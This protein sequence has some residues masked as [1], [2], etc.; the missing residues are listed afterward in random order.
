M[1]R[2]DHSASHF[3]PIGAFAAIGDTRTAAIVDDRGEIGW[4]CAPNFDAPSL[5][6][7]IL[8]PDRGGRFAVRPAHPFRTTRRYFP[9][10][11][12]LESTFRTQS[13]SLRVT[14]CMPVRNGEDG[15][16]ALAP[17]HEVLRKIECVEGEIEVELLCEPRPDYGRRAPR[18]VKRGVCGVCL[19]SGALLPT[20]RSDLPLALDPKKRRVV[21]R[22]TLRAGDTRWA[23]LSIDTE[24]PEALAP[25]GEHAERR[26]SATSSAWRGW[27]ERCTYDGFSPEHVMRSALALK[28]MIFSPS[29]AVVAA[30]TTSLPEKIGGVRNWDYRYCWLRDA[31]LVMNALQSLCFGAEADA[32]LGWLLHATR[33]TA[34]RFRPLY[35][36]WGQTRLPE[37][38]LE[39]LRG[40]RD[41]RPVRVGNAATEQAQ[42]DIYGA[43]IGAA[44]TA[45]L[46]GAYL[47]RDE[48]R[49]L[50]RMGELLCDLWAQADEGLWEPRGVRRHHTHS[51]FM[52]LV[53]FECLLEM[54]EAEG[55]AAPVERFSSCRDAIRDWME[56]CAWNDRLGAYA[57]HEDA[58]T[59]D[60]A[61]LQM[62]NLGGLEIL[63]RERL[64]STLNRILEDLGDGPL[65]K[66]YTRLE[67][68][69][70]GEEGAFVICSFW[71]VE[72]LARLG[73]IDEAIERFDALCAHTND[74]GLLA[75]EIDPATGE[76]LGNTP[77]AFSHVGLINAAIAIDR[78]RRDRYESVREA[79]WSASA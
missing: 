67:D 70:P 34:P 66:R 15:D 73:R 64:E 20:L 74:V 57:S 46:S 36:V 16:D 19:A 60:A 29:G 2:S 3:R 65:I 25:L 39:H 53:G 31:T 41:S 68:G 56:E 49:L 42:I 76:A 14:D 75:E 52:C 35:S 50:V 40:H 27:S 38:S 13:G 7:S 1:P 12:V 17:R 48:R 54:H 33:L 32:F 26:L 58:E 77:Q 69:L 78:A 45:V 79:E 71:G 47:Q 55:L 18:P 4:L 11:N 63:P 5:F 9:R 30:P 6:A 23:S 43:V 37:R 51:K 72:A 44:H 8:D 24:A 10:T 21:G 61:A 28:M 22:E 59:L 62:I